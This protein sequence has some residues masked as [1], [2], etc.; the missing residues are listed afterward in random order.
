MNDAFKK[1]K[2]ERFVNMSVSQRK[3]IMSNNNELCK[4]WYE[5][6]YV[7]TMSFYSHMIIPKEYAIQMLGMQFGLHKYMPSPLQ[8]MALIHDDDKGENE[9]ESESDKEIKEEKN[10]VDTTQL[11]AQ[12]DGSLQTVSSDSNEN[13][14]LTS[15]I[16]PENKD[17]ADDDFE[18]IGNNH[19]S[20]NKSDKELLAIDNLRETSNSSL[21]QAQPRQKHP[22]LDSEYLWNFQLWH[23]NLVK[24]ATNYDIFQKLLLLLFF[25]DRKIVNKN[26]K[27]VSHAIYSKKKFYASANKEE[28]FSLIS[29][30]PNCTTKFL[31]EL[32]AKLICL[33]LSSIFN[34]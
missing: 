24:E 5:P 6:D 18:I 23:L 22:M 8:I 31:S 27:H 29:P 25:F 9:N 11:I 14:Q 17:S 30:K 32:I 2:D 34:M 13:N 4:Y 16:I 19:I 10:K 7:W 3:A 26:S 15:N 21:L 12:M 28:K 33:C 1:K 20:E